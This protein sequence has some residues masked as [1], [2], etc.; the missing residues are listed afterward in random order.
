MANEKN[1]QPFKEFITKYSQVLLPII[2]PV[3]AGIITVFLNISKMLYMQQYFEYFEIDMKYVSIDYV[4]D[5][6]NMAT[7]YCRNVFTVLNIIIDTCLILNIIKV[8]ER[9]FSEREK[10]TFCY[11]LNKYLKK[12][13]I[14]TIIHDFF[15]MIY[16]TFVIEFFYI[17][18]T[19]DIFNP[20][21]KNF[22]SFT[23]HG[24]VTDFKVWFIVES[25]LSMIVA[26]FFHTYQNDKRDLSKTK[27][28]DRVEILYEK[29]FQKGSYSETFKRQQMEI[30]KEYYPEKQPSIFRKGIIA[31]AIASII[32]I[33]FFSYYIQTGRLSAYDQKEFLVTE[34]NKHIAIPV[35]IDRYAVINA[36]IRGE[37]LSLV[38]GGQDFH[39][40]LD[41]PC[42]KRTFQTVK[43]I[44]VR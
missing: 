15:L 1:R 37:D 19:Q 10:N 18:L 17:L 27:R 29:I 5:L 33:C 39:S 26:A 42:Q 20:K 16:T 36:E 13:L 28:K 40:V 21:I 32:I 6:S 38:M 7:D 43:K 25:G 9:Y 8:I 34:D 4:W 23:V 12:E 30:L 24:F 31:S 2:I 11:T 22:D 14:E 3:A 44:Y 41:Y 35:S